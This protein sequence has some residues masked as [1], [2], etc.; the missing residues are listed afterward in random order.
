MTDA[1]QVR[2]AQAR[3][4]ADAAKA[5]LMATVEE[6]KARL[7]PK[8]LAGNAMQA[9]KDKSIVVADDTVTA[10]KEKPMMAAGIAG[11]TALLIARKPLIA[12]IGRWWRGEADDIENDNHGRRERVRAKEDK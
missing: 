12:A 1:H 7:A 9:A 2:I 4:Q 8:T 11:A 10:V 3:G 6:V 5:R